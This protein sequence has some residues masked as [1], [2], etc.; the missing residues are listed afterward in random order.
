MSRHIGTRFAP[1]VLSQ[2]GLQ[3]MQ[4]ANQ[5]QYTRVLRC[6]T[7]RV[8]RRGA[9]VAQNLRRAWKTCRLRRARLGIAGHQLDRAQHGD[10]RS[11]AC[12]VRRPAHSA[13]QETRAQR[14]IPGARSS[15]RRTS[16]SV[17]CARH[18]WPSTGSYAA[19]RPVHSKRPDTGEVLGGSR[20]TR[21]ARQLLLA[22]SWPFVPLSAVS[23][24]SAHS[25]LGSNPKQPMKSVGHRRVNTAGRPHKSRLLPKPTNTN[26][27][28]VFSLQ[29]R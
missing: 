21:G 5:W 14:S 25:N 8:Q 7:C 24:K 27:L 13:H 29:G 16:M 3:R 15:V 9:V 17:D 20:C 26:R 1:A 11:A 10:L 4:A 18:R 2:I 22:D 23:A 6:R 19:W 28:S 12:G